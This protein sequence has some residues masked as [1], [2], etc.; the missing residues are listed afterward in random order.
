MTDARRD[1]ADDLPAVSG[2]APRRE[3]TRPPRAPKIKGYEIL[4]MLGEAA[5]GRVWR[6]R[7]LSTRRQVALKVP[8]S[9]LLRS[10]KAMARF[11]REIELAARLNHPN[12]ARIYGSG[13]CDG[14]YYY[15]M[16]LIEGAP[17]DQYA[18]QHEL[19]V[20]QTMELMLA[21][22]EAIQHAHQNGVIHRDLKPSNILVDQ[23]GKPRVV[24]FGLARTVL[25]GSTFQTLS[26]DGEVTGTPAYMSPEQAAGQ[27]GRLDTRTDVYSLGVVL[28]ELL[29]GDF[30]YDVTTS[31]L[32]TLQNIRESEPISP[33]KFVRHLDRDIQAIVLKALA[34]EPDERYQSAAE[35]VS[36]IRHWLDGEPVRAR[37]HSSL[38]LLRKVLA[39]RRYLLTPLLVYGGVLAV[40]LVVSD[41]VI[42][43]PRPPSSYA[44][45]SD[46]VKLA[47]DDG[48]TISALYLPN[49]DARFTVL[50]SHGVA[51]DLG[52]LRPF[53]EAYRDQGFSLFAYD[54]HGYGTS[55][56]R[57][58]EANTYRDVTA[59]VRYLIEQ[60]D[61]E[62][63]DIIAH[64][65]SVGAGA[66]AY[67]ADTEP[68]GGLILESAFVSAFRAVTRVRL[69]P[70]DKFENL[71][72]LAD[73]RCPVLIV[74]GLNDDVV[75][76]WHGERLFA[77]AQGPKAKLW[78]ERATHDD[79][80]LV[81][82]PAYWKAIGEFA[83]TI[84]G[85][86]ASDA[87]PSPAR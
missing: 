74:H 44:D 66:A 48:V 86:S 25:D 8:R 39:K 60:A 45:T 59:A 31:T 84:E 43:L 33:S 29:T 87:P 40:V 37:A 71:K 78:V 36:D 1:K 9:D 28:Y 46:I 30:P 67:L 85:R 58:S 20:R 4:G 21:V 83:E 19:S 80:P 47:T 79:I 49:P 62:P 6:A 81:A 63:A 69:A 7:Q 56:G 65:R 23:D 22:C 10:R 27:Q 41:K 64:G 51:E 32:Q 54:Y 42:F 16:E 24:D 15:A 34:K 3:G 68:I 57:P 13:L 35:L 5:Q 14:L 12:I 61:V 73:I 53:L 77:A 2:P 82:G 52:P 11:A 55:T 50:Y 75:A 17:L 72:R 38:Y 70:F 26:T 18:Q 76:P